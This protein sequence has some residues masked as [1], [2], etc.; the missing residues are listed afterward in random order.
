MDVIRHYEPSCLI[1][2]M[3]LFKT[4]GTTLY[5]IMEKIYGPHYTLANPPDIPHRVQDHTKALAGHITLSQEHIKVL[6]GLNRKIYTTTLFREPV[7]RVLSDYY[8]IRDHD[9]DYHI[10][11]R[12]E[13]LE[14]WLNQGF[15]RGVNQATAFFA[16]RPELDATIEEAKENI[17]KYISI[18]GILEEF[19][20]FLT[21]L[22]KVLGWEMVEFQNH[23]V[24][25]HKPRDVDPA[26]T[27]LIKQYNQKDLE[28]YAWVRSLYEQ[29]KQKIDENGG[30]D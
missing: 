11:Y 20:D 13:P 12:D 24:N 15:T 19:E 28:L 8:W 30:L 27:K 22:R 4:G 23:K 17:T 10:S 2:F 25:T 7:A 6:R 5:K 16:G 9:F 1:V 29:R 18:F 14:A 21:T 3:H 26:T